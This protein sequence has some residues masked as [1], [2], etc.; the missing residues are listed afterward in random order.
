VGAGR[1][2]VANDV[3]TG[4]EEVIVAGIGRDVVLPECVGGVT[5]LL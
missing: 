1:G 4:S 2:T 3:G 5:P